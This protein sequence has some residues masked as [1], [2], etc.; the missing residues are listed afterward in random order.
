MSKQVFP[1]LKVFLLGRF[2]LERKVGPAWQEDANPAWQHR[3]I[4]ILLAYLLSSPGRRRSRDQVMDTLWPNL[5][6]EN[7]ANRLNSTVHKLRQL[8]EPALNRPA[9][10]HLLRV[11]PDILLLADAATLWVDIDVFRVAHDESA[12]QR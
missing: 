3:S 6:V 11:E 8:L 10:S 2:H 12:Y 9:N 4:R 5:A 1:P 7:A